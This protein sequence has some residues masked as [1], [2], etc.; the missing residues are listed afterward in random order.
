MF[1]CKNQGCPRSY[2]SGDG[3]IVVNQ[4]RQMR[5]AHNA[6]TQ[7]YPPLILSQLAP[8]IYQNGELPCAACQQV[9]NLAHH[10]GPGEPHDV[11]TLLEN[12]ELLQQYGVLPGD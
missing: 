3:Q 8:R 10:T 6:G 5:T 2:N 12:V 11:N 1:I 9:N 7:V 4:V